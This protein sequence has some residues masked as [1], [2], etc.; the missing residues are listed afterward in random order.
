MPDT[1][2]HAD[3]HKLN[4]TFLYNSM[5]LVQEQEKCETNKNIWINNIG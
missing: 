1:T 4:Y 3:K 2:Q 5:L